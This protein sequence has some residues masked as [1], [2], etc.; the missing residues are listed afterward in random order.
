MLIEGVDYGPRKKPVTVNPS[1]IVSVGYSMAGSVQQ[2]DF[3][4]TNQLIP[5]TLAWVSDTDRRNLQALLESTVKPGGVVT[6]TPDSG[7]DFG[8]GASGAT[9][10]FYV[11]NSFRATMLKPG[12]WEIDITL[13]YIA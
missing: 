1:R 5:I 11:P 2:Y 10:F 8:V 12:Y 3:G 13:R 4:L 7:D 6:F 9:D